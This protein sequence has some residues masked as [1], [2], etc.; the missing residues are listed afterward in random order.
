[1]ALTTAYPT[2]KRRVFPW[3][4]PKSGD[5]LKVKMKLPPRHNSQSSNGKRKSQDRGNE[6]KLKLQ[7]KSPKLEATA[8]D[9]HSPAGPKFHLKFSGPTAAVVASSTESAEPTKPDFSDYVDDSDDQSMSASF[10]V[11]DDDAWQPQLAPEEEEEDWQPGELHP[12][13]RTREMMTSF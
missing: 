5:K 8:V 11:L 10:P 4:Q 1:M 2:V 13:G 7:S 12:D 9:V 6:L 3:H